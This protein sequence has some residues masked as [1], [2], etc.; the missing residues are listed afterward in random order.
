VISLQV[1]GSMSQY[2]LEC[3]DTLQELLTHLKPDHQHLVV[4][5]NGH[6]KPQE[7]W[8]SVLLSDQDSIEI[9]HY[10]GGGCYSIS[11]ALIT[12]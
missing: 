8:A 11:D 3:G 6:L 9:L 2:P 7:S 4:E 1:N 10:M 12:P 5:H